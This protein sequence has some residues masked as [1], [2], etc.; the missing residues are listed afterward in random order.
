[1][2]KESDPYQ[3]DGSSDNEWPRDF[4]VSIYLT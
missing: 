2:D 3:K 1:M 4:E